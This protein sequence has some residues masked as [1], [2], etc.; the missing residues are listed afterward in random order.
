MWHLQ[1]INCEYLS[2]P[3]SLAVANINYHYGLQQYQWYFCKYEVS[4]VSDSH[5]ANNNLLVGFSVS[6]LGCPKSSSACILQMQW[7]WFYVRCEWLVLI[8]TTSFRM[9]LHPQGTMTVAEKV[10]KIED[11][12]IKVT[13]ALV[14]L[15][16]VDS[17]IVR[18]LHTNIQFLGYHQSILFILRMNH[19][20]SS[21]WKLVSSILNTLTS[22][23]DRIC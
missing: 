16:W 7:L 10:I 13:E 2:N 6:I 14:V 1:N 20:S 8:D 23:F 18:L 21:V 12:K 15:L 11:E 4:F 9:I 22:I 19:L 3:K 5:M 17:C